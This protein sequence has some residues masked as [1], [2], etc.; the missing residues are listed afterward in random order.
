MSKIQKG[1]SAIFM[2]EWRRFFSRPV[3]LICIVGIPLFCYFFF[4][5]LMWNGVPERLPVAVVDHDQTNVSRNLIRTLNSMS[6]VE[7]TQKLESYT[8]ARQA[9]QRNEVY[10]FMVIPEGFEA[11]A[12]SGKQPELAFFS[13]D[14]YFVAGLFTYKA[15]K[16]SAALANG[17]VARSVMLAKGMSAEEIAPQLQ[18]VVLNT[19]ALGNPWISYSIFL[20]NVIL[21]CMLELMIFIMTV[22]VIGIEI[23]EGNSRRLLVNSNRS[24]LRLLIGKLLPQTIL[25]TI[26][27]V[28]LQIYLYGYLHFPLQNGILPMIAGMMLMVIASQAVGVFMIG[29]LPSLRLGLS[30]ACLTGVVAF[31]IVG[32]SLPVIAMYKPFHY[33]APL[34]PIRHYFLIYGDQALNG[35]PLWYSLPHYLA[36]AVFI[37]APLPVLPRLKKALYQQIYKP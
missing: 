36:L 32:F 5:T 15:L 23:K 9:M 29:C 10:A 21:P 19:N 1:I 2:R 37:F 20:N 28:L 12:S 27:G 3:Y 14:A 4:T 30:F 11:K 26:L 35:L 6:S 34:F 33:L 7:V 18:P 31:S 24:I 8:A 22:F 16:L 13:N 17:S 25:F